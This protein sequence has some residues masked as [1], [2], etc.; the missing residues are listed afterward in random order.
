MQILDTVLAT[1]IP[2]KEPMSS[3]IPHNMDPCLDGYHSLADSTK[4]ID[5]V[6]TSKHPS[7][8]SDPMV[9]NVMYVSSPPRSSRAGG[10]SS[11]PVVLLPYSGGGKPQ[12][13]V[14][15]LSFK[16]AV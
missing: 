12:A 13:C 2:H 8:T 7:Q 11:N 10:K 1:L 5:L 4:P 6:E 9:A 15:F 14:R 16:L 3:L